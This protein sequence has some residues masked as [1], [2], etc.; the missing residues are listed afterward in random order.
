[1]SHDNLKRLRG[2]KRIRRYKGLKERYNMSLKRHESLK[3]KGYQRGLK[4]K[5]T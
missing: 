4:K 3:R 1:M 5:E 2:P